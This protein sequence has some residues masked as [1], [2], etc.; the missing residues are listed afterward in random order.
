MSDDALAES[1]AP[2]FLVAGPGLLDPNFQRTVVLMGEHDENGALGFVVNRPGPMTLRDVLESVDA[3]LA[4]KAE[5]QG[6][7]DR[8]VF[9]G[10]P[11][12]PNALWLLYERDEGRDAEAVLAVGPRLALGTSRE[13]L[14]RL[15]ADAEAP[16]FLAL[17]GYAGWG[18]GQLER[19]TLEGAWVPLPLAEDLVFDVDVERR[20]EEAVRRLGFAPGT[21]LVNPTGEA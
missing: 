16:R 18:P 10:G 9:V 12:Q 19:E 8:P 3:G 13:V 11:V 2:G 17:L 4:R 20:W 21:F 15:V 5:A 14:E 6:R 7:A 1:M